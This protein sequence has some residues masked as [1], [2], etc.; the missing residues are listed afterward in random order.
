MS[1]ADP[2][3]ALKGLGLTGLEAEIYVHLLIASPCTG[4]S[5]AKGLRKPAA[6]VYKALDT[7]ASK[8][9]VEIEDGKTRQVRPVP[10]HELLEHLSVGFNRL[11]DEAA[12]SLAMLPGPEYDHRIYHLHTLDQV[13]VKCGSMVDS[14]TSMVLADV[15]PESAEL[16][17]PALEASI[18]RG[19]RVAVRCYAPFILDGAE[20]QQAQRG[21]RILA[22]W[23]V[24]WMNLVV[25]GQQSI[26]S[27]FHNGGGE[28]IQ[29][30]WTSSPALAYVHHSG[31]IAEIGYSAVRHVLE[32]ERSSERMLEAVRAV[33]AFR[34]TTVPGLDRLIGDLG[35]LD[36]GSEAGG[37][38]MEINDRR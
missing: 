28:V 16:L 27:V 24:Q 36:R 14:A 8:G 37:D 3:T 7:L 5:V 11:R 26:V 10:Y 4:Y 13:M 9:A 6:N 19:V 33:D 2:V 34:G 20:V 12:A 31:L 15:F 17:R 29:S 21:A 25:D 23:P 30:F 18:A 35:L 32:S 38:E 1:T 22:R